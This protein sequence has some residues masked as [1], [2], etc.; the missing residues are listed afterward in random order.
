M[1]S[2]ITVFS[3]VII[4][5]VIFL[6]GGV[7]LFLKTGGSPL[8]Y[9]RAQSSNNDRQR[10]NASSQTPAGDT[11]VETSTA[12]ETA[13]TETGTQTE[14]TGEGDIH[15]VATGNTTTSQSPGV[16][17]D[18]TTTATTGTQTSNSG[19]GDSEDSA[20][21]NDFGI[22]DGR[23]DEY[24][25][26]DEEATDSTNEWVDHEYS[27]TG[28]TDTTLDDDTLTG[29]DRDIQTSVDSTDTG[30]SNTEY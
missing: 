10:T 8:A 28:M 9:F 4:L 1:S 14:T 16:E 23:G 13:S 21:S 7:L 6:I 3:T 26:Y 2:T 27:D 12:I 22:D 15:S 29:V 18:L 11:S 30:S 5:G 19:D 24:S 25:M 20:E 17:S